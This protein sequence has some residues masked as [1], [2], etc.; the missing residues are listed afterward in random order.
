MVGIAAPAPER[1]RAYGIFN[2]SFD[3][4]LAIGPLAAGALAVW[5]AGLDPFL[6]ATV[7][8]ATVAVLIPLAA[9]SGAERRDATSAEAR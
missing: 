1:G 4:G 2:F 5:A 9:R 3:A 7:L 8:I 6:T